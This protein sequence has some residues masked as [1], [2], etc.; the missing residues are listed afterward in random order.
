MTIPLQALP[1][2]KRILLHIMEYTR[3]ESQ[4]EVPFAIS[5]EGIANAIGI[6]RDNVPRAMKELKSSGL[7]V[8]RVAR[9]EGVY[10]KR[11]VYF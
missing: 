7:V 4:F 11:K 3:F 10:R 6:R 1:V 8:E 2:D 9:V 5:Q